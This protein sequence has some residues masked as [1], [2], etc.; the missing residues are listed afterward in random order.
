VFFVGYSLEAEHTGVRYMVPV[1]AFTFIFGGVGLAKLLLDGSLWQRTAGVLLW[2]WLVVAAVGIY[3]DHIPY[4]NEFA[5]LLKDP[6]QIGLDGGT[7]CGPLWLDDSN[8]DWGQ[9][10]KQLKTWLDRNAPMRSVRLLERF[11][12]S[13]QAYGIS[14]DEVQENEIVGA[15]PSSGLYIISAHFVA[16]IP[17]TVEKLFPGTHSWLQDTPPTAIV[18]HSLY[19]YDFSSG[20]R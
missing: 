9:G 14:F 16:R 3:P 5:C 2:I 8:V 6:H 15:K 10:M 20:L 17:A 4:F 11:G 18:G 12:I 19:V 13:P 1:L 7:R